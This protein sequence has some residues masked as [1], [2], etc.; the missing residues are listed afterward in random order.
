ML[1]LAKSYEKLLQEKKSILLLIKI[2]MFVNG[3]PHLMPINMI[4]DNKMKRYVCLRLTLSVCM[5]VFVYCLYVCYD[6]IILHGYKGIVIGRRLID[7]CNYSK[8]VLL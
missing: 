4:S 1:C 2:E 8:V 6:H 7:L 5:C 3:I